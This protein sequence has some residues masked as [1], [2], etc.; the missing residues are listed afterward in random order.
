MS[1][2][3]RLLSDQ[4]VHCLPFLLHLLDML[5]AKT[6]CLNFRIILSIIFR[7]PIIH[8]C[9]VM[10]FCILTETTD[11]VNVNCISTFEG[12]YQYTYEV[13]YGGGGICDNKESMIRAC[14]DPGSAYVDNQVFRMQFAKCRDV[15]TS[16]NKRK[17]EMLF[18][19]IMTP[20]PL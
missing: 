1:K 15:S 12:V 4:G 19:I 10:P 8:N 7:C 9:T 20:P 17:S 13:R 18:I 2:Q 11:E 16:Y 14:Q 6:P 5:Y 3:Y